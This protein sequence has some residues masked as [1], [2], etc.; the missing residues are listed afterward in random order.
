M[1]AEPMAVEHPPHPTSQLTTGELSTYRKELER[2]IQGIS[3]DAPVQADLRARLAEVL[4]E[5]DDR[6]RLARA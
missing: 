4:A 3:P 6:A 1:P 2:A 5:Q